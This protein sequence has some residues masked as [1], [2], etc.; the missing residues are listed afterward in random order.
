MPGPGHPTPGT[1]RGYTDT[2][3]RADGTLTR[4]TA[5]CG[6]GIYRGELFPAEFQNNLFT[7]EPAG[8]L[9][10]R[11]LIVEEHGQLAGRQRR[12]L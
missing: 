4:P 5:A 12:F 3:L 9:V 7:P 11:M 1:N 6:D 2:E 8:N 10:K